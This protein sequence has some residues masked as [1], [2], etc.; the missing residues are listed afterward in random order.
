MFINCHT[1]IFNLKSV[2]TDRT[3][4]TLL[5]RLTRGKWPPFIVSAI[6]KALRKLLKGDYLD[7]EGLLRELVQSISVDSQLQKYLDKLDT[8][9]PADLHILVEGD[10][11]DLAVGAL[12][13]LLRKL[14][15]QIT[16]NRDADNQTLNDL[17]A[18]I[19]IMIRPTIDEV[20]RNLMGQVPDD[21]GVV[22]LMM[23]ITRGDG[24]DEGLF[25]GQLEDTS[26]TV[27]AFPGRVFP[28]VAVNTLRPTHFARMDYALTQRGFVGVK[29]YPSL[30]YQM[31]TPEMDKV[32]AYCVANDVPLLMHCNAGGFRYTAETAQYCDPAVWQPILTKYPALRICFAHFGG[33]E[34]LTPPA[35][36]ADSWTGRILALMDQFETVYAD[37]SFHTDPMA[38]GEA[39][40][41]YFKNLGGLLKNKTYR[42]R[43][44]FGTDYH[45]VRQRLREDNHWRYWQAKLSDADFTQIAETNPAAFLGLPNAG[46][47]GATRNITRYLDFLCLKRFE[48]EAEL[49]AWALK[50]I[51]RAYGE[52]VTVMVNP[53]GSRWSPNN[54]AHYWV[55][56]YWRTQMWPQ[57]QG[58]KFLEC[59]GLLM[60]QMMF[61]NKEHEA[62]EIFQRKVMEQAENMNTTFLD[63]KGAGARFEAGMDRLTAEQTLAGLISNGDTRLADLAPVADR[64]Y[65][66]HQEGA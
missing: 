40:D 30:G 3:L 10:V 34:N 49:P 28:F 36:A 65:H 46:G 6:E 63:A 55:W 64:L 33:D 17:I 31:N 57:Q 7:E 44:L 24:K 12:R 60:R 14:G 21:A 47:A 42:E 5:N 43:I 48:L 54:E 4:D 56:Q 58:L 1:H 35:V 51:K 9:I 45:L 22:V 13:D 19:A 16:D 26:R 59:G 41:N 15:D 37:I 39:G 52:N 8:D 25:L 66:F 62:P 29:L 11:S 20:T 61:W 2:F 23:D 18:F 53:F 38:G 32:F 50:A 27:L